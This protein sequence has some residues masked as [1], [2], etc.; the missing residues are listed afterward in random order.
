MPS[1]WTRIQ[2]SDFCMDKP[3]GKTSTNKSTSYLVSD[4]IGKDAWSKPLA[5]FLCLTLKYEEEQ[6]SSPY[7]VLPQDTSPEQQRLLQE[8]STAVSICILNSRLHCLTTYTCFLWSAIGVRASSTG[9]PHSQV[10]LAGTGD[11]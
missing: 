2:S 9:L 11:C 8:L 6:G 10:V 7:R 1:C 4:K 3:S 5:A